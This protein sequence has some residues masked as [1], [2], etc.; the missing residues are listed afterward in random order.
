MAAV[1]LEIKLPEAGANLSK[2]QVEKV[3][4][5]FKLLDRDRDGRLTATEVGI[6]H[7]AFGQNPTDEELADM[8]R[9]VQPS[10]LDVEQFIR[11]FQDNYRPP[12]SEDVLVRA[13]EVFDLEDSGIMNVD[14]FKEMLT[15]LGEPMPADEVDA[16]LREAEV[17][18][19][20]RFDYKVLAK[21]LCE[22]PKRIPDV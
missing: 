12:T 5:N 14:K 16:I 21:R 3:Q 11:F 8:L 9:S 4:E 20:G 2:D 22:G 19:M 17:D 15:S 18:E 7:R 10:G 6:L 13:F 1:H